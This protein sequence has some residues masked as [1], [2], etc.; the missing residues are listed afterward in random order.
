MN[1]NQPKIYYYKSSP[2]NFEYIWAGSVHIMMQDIN[3][4]SLDLKPYARI[5]SEPT[6][7]ADIFL[8]NL[9][10]K[11][12]LQK[13]SLSEFNVKLERAIEII[14]ANTPPGSIVIH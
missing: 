14:K 13:I 1:I 2:L 6:V 3:D 8:H 4:D 10:S 11:N 5:I 9:I 7:E 12:A